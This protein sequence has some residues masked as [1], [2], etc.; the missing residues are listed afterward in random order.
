VKD[1]DSGNSGN[2]GLASLAYKKDTKSE[3]HG[4]QAGTSLIP[5]LKFVGF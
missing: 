1:P 2:E 5:I 4:T 3:R